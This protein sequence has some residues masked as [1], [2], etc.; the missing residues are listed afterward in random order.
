MYTVTITNFWAERG[1]DCNQNEKNSKKEER[2]IKEM[3]RNPW[4]TWVSCTFDDT[5]DSIQAVKV[6]THKER[7]EEIQLGTDRN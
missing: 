1:T 6:K 2:I 3:Q 7:Q 5:R 4:F